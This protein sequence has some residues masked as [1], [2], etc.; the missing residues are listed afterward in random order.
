MRKREVLLV[1]FLII[2]G[3]GLMVTSLQV[4]Q[5]RAQDFAPG[6][7]TVLR[8]VYTQFHGLWKFESDEI[9]EWNF[10]REYRGD[11]EDFAI[12]L[13]LKLSEAKEVEISQAWLLAVYRQ[14]S[15]WERIFNRG[16]RGHAVLI[17]R[18]ENEY[19]VFDNGLKAHIL[20][21]FTSLEEA[22]A[23]Y[24]NLY[25]AYKAFDVYLPS[26]SKVLNGEFDRQNYLDTRAPVS[27]GR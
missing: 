8:D 17:V 23:S 11:C 19:F 2:L 1:A 7:S 26:E 21:P 13:F 15:I 27:I 24:A 25:G 16:T 5:V 6:V 22:E 12:T 9:N 18:I 14:P 10:S 20:G 4:H 3:L